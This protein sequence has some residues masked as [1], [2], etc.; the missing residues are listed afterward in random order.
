M[1]VKSKLFMMWLK[2]R[3]LPILIVAAVVVVVYLVFFNK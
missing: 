3:A 2:K 1:S